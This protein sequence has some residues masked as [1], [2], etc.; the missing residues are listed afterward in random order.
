MR[1]IGKV[2]EKKRKFIKVRE[3][4]R[5]SSESIVSEMW[6]SCPKIERF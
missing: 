1:K 2:R 3:R 4:K 5:K 6:G